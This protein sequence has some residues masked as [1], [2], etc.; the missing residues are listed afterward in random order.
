[1]AGAVCVEGQLL[2]DL[3]GLAAVTESWA[4]LP[5]TRPGSGAWTAARWV[6]RGADAAFLSSSPA[7]T[8]ATQFP[9][10]GLSPALHVQ[11]IESPPSVCVVVFSRVCGSPALRSHHAPGFQGAQ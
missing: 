10:E 7:E 6:G 3:P 8:F 9:S 1:M 4:C 2:R 11:F 5:G